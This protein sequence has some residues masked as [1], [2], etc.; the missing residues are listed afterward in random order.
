MSQELSSA[1]VVIGAL[2]VNGRVRLGQIRGG[3]FRVIDRYRQT[4]IN[5]DRGRYERSFRK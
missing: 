4:A 1:A 2:M 5:I 3:L